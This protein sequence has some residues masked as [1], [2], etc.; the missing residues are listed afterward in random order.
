MGQFYLYV[1]LVHKYGASF[2]V[3]KYGTNSVLLGYKFI[4]RVQVHHG[5]LGS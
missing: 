3:H 5:W 1:F 4:L 2:Q